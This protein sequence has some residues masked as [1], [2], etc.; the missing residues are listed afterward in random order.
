MKKTFKEELRLYS[1]ISEFVTEW[2]KESLA[3][4]RLMDSLTDESLNQVVSKDHRTLGQIA[5]HLVWTI[6][7]MSKMG[8]DFKK[9]DG[10]ER[11]PSSA[12]KIASEY[13]Q[14]SQGFLQAVE[15]Q[16]KEDALQQ[17]S[18]SLYFLIVHEIHHR[19]QMTV[20]MRQAGLNPPGVYGPT[21]E[22]WIEKGQQPHI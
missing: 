8:L 19:G 11:A 21:R 17:N 1:K 20:L 22:E 7:Y 3:T 10:E 2:K 16:W 14:L 6:G 5:W 9:A 12:H 18:S 13:K 15:T 4:Q